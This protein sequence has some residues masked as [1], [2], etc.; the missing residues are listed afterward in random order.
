[1][2]SWS[3][4]VF[5]AVAVVNGVGVVVAGVVGVVLVLAVALVVLVA[6]RVPLCMFVGDEVQHDAQRCHVLSRRRRTACWL[7]TQLVAVTMDM[8][9]VCHKRAFLGLDDAL[10]D[11]CTGSQQ[12]CM[13]GRLRLHQEID[14]FPACCCRGKVEHGRKQ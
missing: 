13:A 12:A 6:A 3:A 7:G 14:P 5:V 2:H 1:M 9:R 11:A 8:P 4:L 10:H